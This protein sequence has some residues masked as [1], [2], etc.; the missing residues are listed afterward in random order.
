MQRKQYISSMRSRAMSL[1]LCPH[2]TC[3][4]TVLQLCTQQHLTE[5]FSVCSYGHKWEKMT[6]GMKRWLKPL[7]TTALIKA[8]DRRLKNMAGS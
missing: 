6:P 4:T 7:Y 3:S 2:W 5:C 8:A 1:S